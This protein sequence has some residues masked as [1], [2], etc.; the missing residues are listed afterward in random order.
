[1]KKNS[2]IRGKKRCSKCHKLL[3][4]TK[5]HFQADR[6]RWDGLTH[7][8]RSCR[9]QG[10]A[11]HRGSW[12]LSKK[13]RR[14]KYQR[15]YGKRWKQLRRLEALKHYGGDPPRCACC[16][17]AHIEFLSID[18]VGGGGCA[19]RKIIKRAGSAFCLWLRQ[20]G[21][22]R[23][24]RV[25]CHNCNQAIGFYGACPHQRKDRKDRG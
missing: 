14:S 2:Y 10:D 23:G 11:K 12:S 21:Y 19:H 3:P 13:A 17:E 8:C 18:H 24:Y 1:M 4:P 9:H 25:L 16:G 6:T 22:P 15:A 7:Q 5:D 20:R